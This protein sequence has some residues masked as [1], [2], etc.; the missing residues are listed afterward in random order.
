MIWFFMIIAR[1]C[2]RPPV[3][4]RSP[5]IAES[6]RL[7]LGC[8]S[9][10]RRRRP[11]SVAGREDTRDP[12]WHWQAGL[13]W[14]PGPTGTSGLRPPGAMPLTSP[15]PGLPGFRPGPAGNLEET[16]TVTFKFG[17]GSRFLRPGHWHHLAAA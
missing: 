15:Q 17:H 12:P 6:P 7:A 13:A 11:P 16:F 4:A 1:T 3:R 5:M 8:D 9:A 2:A 10:R 14:R